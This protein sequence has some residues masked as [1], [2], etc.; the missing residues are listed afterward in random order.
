MGSSSSR[1]SSPTERANALYLDLC[2]HYEG[3]DDKEV[4][5]ASKMLM[6][7]LARLREHGGANWDVTLDAYV[8]VA[9]NRPEKLDRILQ[10]CN[11]ERK[12]G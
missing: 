9:K 4:R 3:G 6:V 7:A 1:R 12:S 8:K 10:K 5:A 2:S 11:R